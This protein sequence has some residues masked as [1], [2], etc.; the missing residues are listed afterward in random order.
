MIGKIIDFVYLRLSIIHDESFSYIG[1]RVGVSGN[2]PNSV[3]IAV[4]DS[5]VF[6]GGLIEGL[7]AA[8]TQGFLDVYLVS[9]PVTWDKT[10]N[11]RTNREII[12]EQLNRVIYFFCYL[13]I[14]DQNALFIV[15]IENIEDYS[16]PGK[17]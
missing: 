8:K 12:V 5:G 15:V 2:S 6:V 7:L 4:N 11:M 9:L 3:F 1:G 13:F 16:Y 14:F 10:Q 17:K